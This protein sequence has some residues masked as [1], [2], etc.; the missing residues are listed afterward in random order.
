MSLYSSLGHTNLIICFSDWVE[1]GDPVD[2]QAK[3]NKK[4]N[5]IKNEYG[6]QL[7]WFC[8]TYTFHHIF[9]YQ[10]FFILKNMDPENPRNI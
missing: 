4:M 2:R 10:L 7:W 1:K 8:K 3:K 5:I 9:S 6:L